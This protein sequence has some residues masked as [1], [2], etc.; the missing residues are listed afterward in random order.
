MKFRPLGATG[1]KVSVI[2][3][4][5]IKLPNL[6]FQEA[7]KVVR[8]ALDLGVN[9]IDTARIYK[10]SE[11]KIGEAIKNRREACYIATK[12]AGK[13]LETSLEALGVDYIDL[14]QLHS[15]SDRETYHS[16]MRQ[17]G[18][19]E[20]LKE[21]RKK[22]W[23]GHIGV[24]C[25]RDLAVMRD[26]ISSGEFETIMVAYSPIDQ[27]NVTG[28]IDLASENGMGVIAM[29][30]LS[31]GDLTLPPVVRGEGPD[32]V[33]AGCLRWVLS[34]KNV[35]TAIPGMQR[36][37]EVEENVPIGDTKLELDDQEKK[38][39][40]DSIC[41]SI[42]EFG[43]AFRYGQRCLRCHYCQ[44]CPQ[45]I[46]IPD[47]LKALDMYRGYPEQLKHMGTE[48]YRSLDV[49]PDACVECLTCVEKCPAHLPIPELLKEALDTLGKKSI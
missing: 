43:R 25:H 9:F 44:P 19:L 4:G 22:G 10:D 8:K 24:S 6:P 39:I 36:I 49:K 13:D 1:L 37:Q 20:A 16:V 23:I 41:E 31:G 29:K 26:L 12:T 45:G 15:V 5:G 11:R 14:M 30:P 42:G 21:A 28:V 3:F 35:S 48:L 34:N 27:E 7:V 47:V 2:G 17:G 18:A 33:V 46:V 40:F 32:H 38:E